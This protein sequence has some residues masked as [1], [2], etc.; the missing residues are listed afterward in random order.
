MRKLQINLN[1]SWRD[2]L[3]FDERATLDVRIHARNLATLAIGE[4]S[5]RIAD[6][7]NTC[8]EILTAPGYAWRAMR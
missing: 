7:S 3:R 8:L 5:M 1:G 4:P 2:V 6:E